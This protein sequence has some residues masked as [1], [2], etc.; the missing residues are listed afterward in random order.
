M[1]DDINHTWAFWK[2]LM[3]LIAM[4]FVWGI[5]A[6]ALDITLQWDANTEEDLAGYK[7]YYKTE[8]SGPSYNGTGAVEGSSPIDVGDTM[9]T[10]LHGLDENVTYFFAVTAYN[11]DQLESGF[12]NEVDALGMSLDSG[13][14]LVSLYRQPEN[15]SL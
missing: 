2:R 14:N 11:T 13:S 9:E 5:P 3:L 8:T 6:Y 15:T 4:F 12:S 7:V 1:T 10:T